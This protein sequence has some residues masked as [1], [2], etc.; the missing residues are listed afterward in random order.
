MA[1]VESIH[2]SAAYTTFFKDIRH[3]HSVLRI[4]SDDSAGT[5]IRIGATPDS[6]SVVPVFYCVTGPGQ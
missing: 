4:L 6:Q 1:D 5:A 2:T 3:A